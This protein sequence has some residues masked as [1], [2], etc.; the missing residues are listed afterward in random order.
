MLTLK[1]NSNKSKKNI[2]LLPVSLKKE[3]Q[4]LLYDAGIRRKF[5]QKN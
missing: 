4:L 3:Q 2:L 1:D 5:C